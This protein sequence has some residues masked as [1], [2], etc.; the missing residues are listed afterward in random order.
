MKLKTFE[1]FLEDSFVLGHPEVLDDEMPDKFNAWVEELDGGE[2]FGA[3][4]ECVD[5]LNVK[6]AGLI[7]L[8]D[9]AIRELQKIKNMI[10]Q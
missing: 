9:E 4:S 2:I 8:A 3:A 10:N 5:K 7:E 1:D 6:I